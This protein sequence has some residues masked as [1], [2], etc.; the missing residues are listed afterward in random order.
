MDVIRRRRGGEHAVLETHHLEKLRTG[1]VQDLIVPIWVESEYK[2]T[3]SLKRGLLIVDALLEDLKESRSFRLVMSHH[4]L[5]AA[6]RER[7]I[8]LIL[9]VE[10]GEIIE[11]ELGLLRV[12]H[13]LGVRCFGLM[14]NQRNLLAD[15]WDHINDERG[16]TQFGNE[17]VVELERLRIIVDL[18]HMAPKSF[19]GTIEVAK[20]P[21]IVSHTA[22][23]RHKSLR[24]LTDDQLR[25]VADKNGIIGIFAVNTGTDMMMMPD[26]KTYCDHVEHAVEVA[27]A[28]HVGLGP[29]FYDYF[30]EDLQREN[31]SSNFQLV[32]GIEDHSKLGSVIAELSR[33]GLSERDLQF[34]SRENFIRVFREVVG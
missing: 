27:G 20:K 13:R 6:R 3:A 17:V 34:I 23:S 21:L 2:P 15:G 8:G 18:A 24:S 10:G 32:K 31:P 4:E 14:W 12:F 25:A 33:R 29:D 22:T 9:G 1:H 5:I 26:L 16:L 30:L 11:D 28:E 7:K 19:W